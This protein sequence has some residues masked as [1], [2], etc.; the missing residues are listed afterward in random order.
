M[1]TVK[2]VSTMIAGLRSYSERSQAAA[3]GAVAEWGKIVAFN[4][5]RDGPWTDRTGRARAEL[6]SRTDF[7]GSALKVYIVGVSYQVYLEFKP[8]SAGGRPIIVE[9]IQQ[10]KG[11]LAQLLQ[12]AL[13]G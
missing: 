4:S 9:T 13:R 12:Q 7:S 2:G 11:L 5:R 8:R 10:S 1:A 6:S 3:R